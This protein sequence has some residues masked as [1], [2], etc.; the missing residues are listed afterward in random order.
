MKIFKNTCLQGFSIPFQ[1]PEGI[2]HFFIGSKK[3]LET[4]DNWSSQVAENL[5]R[6]RMFKITHVADLIPVSVVNA[7]ILP[8]SAPVITT[9]R[10]KRENS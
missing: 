6:R 2:K 4:P 5:V 1:T 3:S 9:A 10:T 8:I 7:T